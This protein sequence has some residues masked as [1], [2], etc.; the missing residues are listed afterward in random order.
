MVSTIGTV[1]VVAYMFRD[2]DLVHN[3][4]GIAPFTDKG[5]IA[6]FSA[7]RFELFHLERKPILLGTRHN[8]NLWRIALSNN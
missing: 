8:G 1:T 6:T 3:L 4:F 7:T 5:C 2:T